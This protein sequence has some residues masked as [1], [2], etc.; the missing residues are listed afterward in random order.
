MN[1]EHPN[2]PLAHYTEACNLLAKRYL[3]P[4]Y[5]SA[6]SRFVFLL[7]SPHIQ[8]LR[9]G[10]PVCGASGQ[11]MSAHLFGSAYAHLP[12]G[13]IVKRNADEGLDRPSINRIG[14]MNTCQIPLQASA[15]DAVDAA[16]HA[17]LLAAFAALRTNNARDRYP[18]ERLMAVQTII[19][20]HLRKKLLHLQ[21]QRLA[22]VPCGRFAQKFLRLAAVTSAH[23]TI[24]PDI[25]H[26]SYNNWSKPSYH[27]PVA[28][29]CRRF[30]QAE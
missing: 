3:V 6:H 8:E 20:R 27:E 2:Q 17:D 24:I 5:V 4:D 19:V 1:P 11:S 22:L 29:L 15:Y 28:E 26:P 10:A 14:L 21:N 13:V 16:Q 25:P 30:A 7:E 23:W 9:L 18:D 12:L